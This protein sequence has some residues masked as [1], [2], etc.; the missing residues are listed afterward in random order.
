ME[1]LAQCGGESGQLPTSQA[2]GIASRWKRHAKLGRLSPKGEPGGS[3][4]WSQNPLASIRMF[5]TLRGALC[6]HL[7]A[8]ETEAQRG[9]SLN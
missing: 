4:S 2:P 6:P 8:E 3:W 7:T 1:G 5:Y 9:Q